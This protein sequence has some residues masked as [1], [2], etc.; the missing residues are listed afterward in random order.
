MKKYFEKFSIIFVIA[1]AIMLGYSTNVFAAND[2]YTD[3]LIPKMTSDT[4]PNGKVTYSSSFNSIWVGYKAFDKSTGGAAW[5]TASNQSKGWLA[6]EFDAPKKISRYSITSATG[7]ANNAAPK[8]WA[9]EGS[10]DG[11][12]WVVIDSQSNQ[13]NW[14]DLEKRTYTTYNKTLFKSYRIRIIESNYS[15][16]CQIME[17]EMMG[18]VTDASNLSITPLD[19]SKAAG[20]KQQLQ[21]IATMNDGSI[22]DVTSG[23]GTVYSSMDTSVAT[24]DENGLVSV[25]PDAPVGSSS[26]I[27]AKYGGEWIEIVI[28]VA[29]K[30]SVR[31]TDLNI[32]PLDFSK[33]AGE[34]Q[35]L[36][37]IATMSDGSTKDVTSGNGTIYSSMDTSVATVDENGI[38]TVLSDAR[39]GSSS[40]IRATYGG[41]S[42]ESVITVIEKPSPTVVSL[43]VTPEEVRV[44]AGTQQQL[45]VIA[46]MSDGS[47]KDVTAGSNGTVYESYSTLAPVDENGL[48]TVLAGARTI[49][50]VSYGGQ[51]ARCWILADAETTR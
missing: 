40:R 28:T 25:L 29:E 10:N 18:K 20:E 5:C 13:V 48:V 3:N 35:Q 9:F 15:S 41:K 6:Y 39:V 26:R 4:S 33:I 22:K 11:T 46:T 38:V 32:T 42:I 50:D 8:S 27:S 31:V 17:M 19:F 1:L 24:V 37:V 21:V 47:T 12:S 14:K 43:S 2:I 23:N 51:T 45:Q 49:I 7:G 30:P 16:L 34:K 36:Q 44:P